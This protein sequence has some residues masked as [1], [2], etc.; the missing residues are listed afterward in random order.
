M[1]RSR[2]TCLQ[3][4]TGVLLSLCLLAH[5]V[6]ACS[7]TLCWRFVIGRLSHRPRFDGRLGP[8]RPRLDGRLRCSSLLID[9]F[10]VSPQGLDLH[11]CPAYKADAHRVCCCP[12]LSQ[13][14]SRSSHR[15]EPLSCPLSGLC[16]PVSSG[17]DTG[18]PSIHTPT[19]G[20][21]RGCTQARL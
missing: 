11:K 1:I 21:K 2:L 15:A 12:D 3:S 20:R 10:R 17:L 8:S 19:L 5:L 14:S 13:R 16:L 4:L 7:A 6:L 9:T 18:P